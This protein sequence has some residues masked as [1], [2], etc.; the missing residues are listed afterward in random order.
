MVCV[1]GVWLRL[2]KLNLGIEKKPQCTLGTEGSQGLGATLSEA[3]TWRFLLGHP[4]AGFP[5][6]PGLALVLHT[7]FYQA[8]SP[9]KLFLVY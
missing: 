1:Q 3:G 9:L 7:F 5:A 4:E 8:R 6:A 2:L